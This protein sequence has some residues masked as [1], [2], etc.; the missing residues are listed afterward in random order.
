M[1]RNNF[2]VLK[3]FVDK[4]EKG[5]L[6]LEEILDDEDVVMDIKTNSNCPLANL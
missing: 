3:K 6:Q 2:Q 1:Y 5:E 4:M